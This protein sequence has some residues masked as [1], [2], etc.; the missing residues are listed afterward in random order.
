MFDH[1]VG[2]A[3]KGLGQVETVHKNFTLNKFKED[4]IKATRQGQRR[5]LVT[6]AY[7]AHIHSINLVLLEAAFACW[8]HWLRTIN[9]ITVSNCLPK[10]AM[11]TLELSL[12]PALR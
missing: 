1:F 9:L 5:H 8:R 3:L 4:I 6:I 2:L 12:K 10:S 7:A 11:S